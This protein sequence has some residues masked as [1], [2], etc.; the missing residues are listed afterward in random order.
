MP[1]GTKVDR[2]EKQ[3]TIWRSLPGPGS[4]LNIDLWDKSTKIKTLKL[5]NNQSFCHK[6]KEEKVSNNAIVMKKDK[7]LT[8]E[9][10]KDPDDILD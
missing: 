9:S 5:N 4:Y 10:D 8:L 2:F 7:F 6:R 1:F 3:T